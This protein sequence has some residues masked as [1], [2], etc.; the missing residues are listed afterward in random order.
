MEF[1]LNDFNQLCI[2]FVATQP[3]GDT[4]MESFVALNRY[5]DINTPNLGRSYNDLN[6]SFFWSRKWAKSNYN[7][8]ALGYEYPLMAVH[9]K[10]GAINTPFTKTSSIEIQFLQLM[11]ID[12]YD[13]TCETKTLSGQVART[14]NEI[15]ADCENHMKRFLTYLTGVVKT[16]VRWVHESLK[17]VEELIDKTSTR[18][19]QNS[20]A[21]TNP[22][23]E[24]NLWEG[25]MDN[26]SGVFI[27]F[28]IKIPFC[29]IGE[30]TFEETE[31]DLGY[32]RNK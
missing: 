14:R 4:R 13:P 18:S 31:Y 15:Y 16:D 8:S 7:P 30:L 26:V 12:V 28:A 22:N 9:R 27:D 24:T 32:D 6:K 25:G 29:I 20:L 19:F 17:G 5:S 21:S 3:P 10:R 1:T 11:F 23:V 2:D